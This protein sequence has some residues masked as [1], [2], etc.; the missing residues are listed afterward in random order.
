MNEALR[1]GQRI[2]WAERCN[3][4]L[5]RRAGDDRREAIASVTFTAAQAQPADNDW[6]AHVS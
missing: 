4:Y 3:W 2:A 1:V 5:A 6:G